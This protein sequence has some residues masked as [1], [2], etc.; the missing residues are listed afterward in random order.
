MSEKNSLSREKTRSA[1]AE[2]GVNENT[3]CAA[4][5]THRSHAPGFRWNTAFWNTVHTHILE[6]EMIETN[7]QIGPVSQYILETR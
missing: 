7:L 2:L 1:A 5:P 6:T 4:D 3:I